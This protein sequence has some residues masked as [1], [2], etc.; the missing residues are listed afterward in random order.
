MSPVR[1]RLVTL[2][3]LLTGAIVAF[4]ASADATL[5]FVEEWSGTGLYGW[6]GGA[7]YSNP[8]AG[9]VLGDADGY[10]ILSTPTQGRLAGFSTTSSYQGDWR[11][12]GITRL[13]LWLN[14][15]GADQPLEIHVMLISGPDLWIYN[16]GFLPPEQS[17]AQ[18]EVDLSS[19]SNFTHV[20]GSGTFEHALQY[21]NGV[22]IRHDTPPFTTAA[23]T[24][25]GD[26]GI[27]HL[28]LTDNAVPARE[29]TWARL[30]ALYR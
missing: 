20:T 27:D 10:L 6:G 4:R 3:L 14:D 22:H 29:W 15:V 13:R 23:D 28:E 2:S 5:G 11:A 1:A 8:G 19:A 12:A 21:M 18:F 17:W 30:K 9:G 26:V 7:A 16:T 24:I 25:Q